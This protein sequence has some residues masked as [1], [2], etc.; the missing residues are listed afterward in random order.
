MVFVGRD[1]FIIKCG[2]NAR[3]VKDLQLEGK[4]R[5]DSKSFL[6]GNRIKVGESLWHNQ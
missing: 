3:A 2:K 1:D 4:K 5:M 6:L